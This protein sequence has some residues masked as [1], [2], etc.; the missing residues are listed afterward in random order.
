MLGLHCSHFLRP[1]YPSTTPPLFPTYPRTVHCLKRAQFYC[2]T[3][4]QKQSA[5]LR[6]SSVQL[7]N[8]PLCSCRKI[9]GNAKLQQSPSRW[10]RR[11]SSPRMRN[12]T[13]HKQQK[14]SEEHL[15]PA[16][17]HYTITKARS[18][19]K[20]CSF[21]LC[22]A[23]PVGICHHTYPRIKCAYKWETQ[24]KSSTGKLNWLSRHV[25]KSHEQGHH[26][27]E[28]CQYQCFPRM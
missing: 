8:G 2:S 5:Q 25:C 9:G 3:L 12:V 21:R 16:A 24:K 22:R 1:Q 14:V 27:A 28:G 4:I 20:N 15:S 6:R 17:A 18:P 13:V 19:D 23:N 11:M 7:H 10:V 26:Y